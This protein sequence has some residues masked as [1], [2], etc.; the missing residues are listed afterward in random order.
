MCPSVCTRTCMLSRTSVYESLNFS[1]APWKYCHDP[2]FVVDQRNIWCSAKVF[3]FCHSSIR[4]CGHDR[5]FLVSVLTF[6]K[7]AGFDV[8]YVFAV[9]MCKTATLFVLVGCTIH[10]LA[11]HCTQLFSLLQWRYRADISSQNK[12]RGEQMLTFRFL[13]PCIVSKIWREKT[14]KMQRLDAYY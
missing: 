6:P 1:V 4:V 5:P 10:L 3:S 7:G 12:A 8:T 14:N 9:F 13:W 11:R 2:V